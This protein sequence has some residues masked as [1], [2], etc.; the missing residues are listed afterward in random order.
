MEVGVKTKITKGGNFKAVEI[1]FS[2]LIALL[3]ILLGLQGQLMYE[4]L[5]PPHHVRKEARLSKSD[6]LP[7]GATFHLLPQ[8]RSRRS[9][10]NL[11]HEAT[12]VD[13]FTK[14]ELRTILTHYF[15]QF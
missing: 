6:F 3:K 5:S 12:K 11:G 8:R 7:V 1:K 10:G 15:T 13:E 4:I 2:L 14:T 9:T